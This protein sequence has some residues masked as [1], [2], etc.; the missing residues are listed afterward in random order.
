MKAVSWLGGYPLHE[1][2][3][4]AGYSQSQLEKAINLLCEC[5]ANPNQRNS[6]GLTP[7]EYL[8]KERTFPE[9][10][11]I[12]YLLPRGAIVTY[13]CVELSLSLDGDPCT[14]IFQK[15]MAGFDPEMA[16]KEN[17]KADEHKKEEEEI[18]EIMDSALLFASYYG[19]LQE[20]QDLVEKFGVDVNCRNSGN[21]LTFLTNG[22]TPL[23][24]AAQA[25][26]LNM[27]MVRLLKKMGGDPNLENEDGTSNFLLPR[28]SR[29][30]NNWY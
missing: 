24:A 22:D 16:R 25:T 11:M 28:I 8:F 5:G 1:L 6:L 17:E 12:D 30:G 9:W 15:L 21:H 18:R 7:L 26:D 4:S 3:I 29:G 27:D 19:L 13:P 10:R 14:W 20:A 2:C 23:L